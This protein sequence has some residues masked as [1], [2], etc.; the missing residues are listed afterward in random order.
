MID[1]PLPALFK[2]ALLTFLL[3]STIPLRAQ[4]AADQPT[5]S[6][7]RPS[8]ANSAVVVPKDYFQAENGLLS[9]RA[10]GQ[11][12]VDFPETSLRFGLLDKTELRLS[13]PD[14]FDAVSGPAFSGFG[15]MAIGV[16]QQLGP[17]PDG[18]NFSAIFY[19]TLPTGS[20]SISS[21]GYDPAIQL[22]WSHAL[23]ANWT[24]SGQAAFYWPTE[25]GHHTFTG[26]FT[27]V[28]DRQL[29]KPWDAF[30]EYA[31]D[32]PDHPPTGAGSRQILHFGSAYKL[33]PRHQIDFQVAAGLTPD[34]PNMYIG[35]GYSFF[36][37]V[38][39]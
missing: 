26:E 33:A 27:V 16:K 1:R 24:A 2:P 18:F 31:G 36:F 25:L 29:T 21:H 30:L 9:T 11:Y 10:A 32:F 35:V 19:L 28:L 23:S 7:D 22:P 6:T 37:R 14:F 8:V 13:V 3:F 34:A 12:V 17:T 5:I 15:D 4:T 38:T 39:Q 20:K